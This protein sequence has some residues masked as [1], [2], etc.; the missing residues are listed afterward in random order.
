MA[1]PFNAPN[2]DAALVLINHIIS[3]EMQIG[4]YDVRNWGDLPVLDVNRLSQAQRNLLDSIDN[5]I[6]I[7]TPAELQ[8]RRVPEVQ[9]AKIPIIDRLWQIHVLGTR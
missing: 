4:K 2:K 3:P 1:I 7:L 8:A 5:G 9:A 6:G